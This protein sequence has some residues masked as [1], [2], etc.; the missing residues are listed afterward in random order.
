M[1]HLLDKPVL[2]WL[3]VLLVVC[4]ASFFASSLQLREDAMDMLPDAMVKGDMAIF[5]KLGLVNRVYINVGI[6]SAEPEISLAQ[7][8]ALRRSVE[9][10]GD[11]LAREPLFDQTSYRLDPGYELAFMEDIRT[12]LPEMLTADD[13]LVLETKVS[14]EGVRT[15]LEGVFRMLNSPAGIA[16]AK[17]IVADPLGLTLLAAERLKGMRGEFA[18]NLRDGLFVAEDGKNCLIWAD[19]ATSLTD[20]QNARDVNRRLQKIIADSLEPG[21]S[22]YTIGTLPHTLSN[23]NMVDKDLKLLLPLATIVLAVFLFWVFR[24]MKAFLVLFIPFLAALP[25]LALLHYIYPK[26]SAMA[27]GFGIVL[28]GLAVDFAVHIYLALTR[29]SGG[30]DAILRNLR[31]PV[32]LAWITTSAV[33]VILLSSSVSSHRQMALLALFGITF[34][35]IF[36]WL[37]VPTISGGHGLRLGGGERFFSRDFPSGPPQLLICA[38]VLFLTAG[39]FAWPHLRYNGDM[40]VLDA[41]NDEI[42]RTDT[43]FKNKWRRADDQA[44]VVA[45]GKN[46]DEVLD[47][48]DLVNS[49]LAEHLGGVY[50]SMAPMLPGLET[51]L[52]RHQLWNSFWT[53]HRDQLDERMRRIGVELGFR[54]DSFSPFIASLHRDARIKSSEELLSGPFRSLFSSM[55]RDSGTRGP[56]SVLALTVVPLREGSLPIIQ[57]LALKEKHIHV[58]SSQGW[59]R[60]VEQMLRSDIVR[61]SFLGIAMVCIVALFSFRRF[62]PVVAALA[63]VGSALSAM[64]LWDFCMGNGMNLMHVLMG[65]MVIGLAVDYGIF[66]V[67]A[68]QQGISAVTRRAVS[69][70]AVSSCIGFGVLSLAGHPAL[71]SLGSTV[72]IGIGLAWPT[73]IWVTPAILGK[74][75][76]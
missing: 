14:E 32:L 48:N 60:D 9:K 7:W 1:S 16:M 10:M 68:H 13:Y 4:G 70:C 8:G 45:T 20:S 63:P 58:I 35:V 55:V 11:M 15:A 41:V 5:N 65:L 67:C 34:A 28:T 52:Q 50:H 42:R 61:L 54:P 23:I 74:A 18:V 66:S 53:I 44:F 59:R 62:R 40:Q 57:N 51:R 19:A 27:L 12:R 24:S 33:F 64:A 3:L 37:L 31:R 71:H 29:E 21:I 30:R 25:S 76:Q 17:Q 72:L 73:A 6:D 39:A 38:W 43:D 75:K 47:R 69:V 49:Y 36:S 46:L 22:A 56:E 26:I 2:K